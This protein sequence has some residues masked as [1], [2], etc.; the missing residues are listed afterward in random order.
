MAAALTLWRHP[1]VRLPAG[2]CYGRL[3]VEAD[4]LHQWELCAQGCT[5]W[6]PQPVICSPARRC[7]GLAEAVAAAWGQPCSVDRRLQELD[8]GAWEG[9]PWDDIPRAEIDR[10]AADPIDHAPG[11]GE[12]LRQLA[13]RVQAWWLE[14]CADGGPALVV[15]HGGPMRVLAVLAAGQP[16]DAVPGMAAPAFPPRA[17]PRRRRDR[18]APPRAAAPARAAPPASSA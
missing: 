17:P 18:R 8:F 2:V 7:R 1:R 10:W 15:G 3:D 14:R 9:R 5:R 12:S 13:A 6:S 11:G 16:L 4:A